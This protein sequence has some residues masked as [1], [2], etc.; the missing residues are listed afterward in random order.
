MM[1]CESHQWSA[2]ARWLRWPHSHRCIMMSSCKLLY[3][4]CSSEGIVALVAFVWLEVWGHKLWWQ[5]MHLTIIW[6]GSQT[7]PLGKD[8]SIKFNCGLYL[9]TLEGGLEM[10]ISRDQ[11]WILPYRTISSAA[12]LCSQS[13]EVFAFEP[14]NQIIQLCILW[15][16]LCLAKK[17]WKLHATAYCACQSTL[18]PSLALQCTDCL[19]DKKGGCTDNVYCTVHSAQCT[20]YFLYVWFWVW[21]TAVDMY[22][23]RSDS[24]LQKRANRANL[25]VL[26]FPAGANVLANNAKNCVHFTD[27][28]G[29]HHCKLYDLQCVYGTLLVLPLVAIF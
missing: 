15:K 17:D 22:G 24:E 16:M 23:M 7:F 20:P 18:L 3:V 1:V 28:T 5:D 27:D 25:L 29:S 19:Y 14:A 10:V 9:L 4:V 11:K 13:Q 6:V 2:C 21:C 12:F 26:I 8:Q